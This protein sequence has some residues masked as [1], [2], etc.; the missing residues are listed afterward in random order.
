MGQI[1][2][3]LGIGRAAVDAPPVDDAVTP[4]R[5]RRLAGWHW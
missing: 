4:V 1:K 5:Q 3:L 2:R